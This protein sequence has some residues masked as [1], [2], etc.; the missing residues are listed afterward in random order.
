MQE[1]ATT[2]S[3]LCVMVSDGALGFAPSCREPALARERPLTAAQALGGVF[4]PLRSRDRRSGRKSDEARQSQVDPNARNRALGGERLDF[5]LEADEPLAV[6]PRQDGSAD[7]RTF[8][9]WS[10]PL[11][12]NLT[13]NAD[14]PE[15]LA[16]SDREAVTDAELGAD[17]PTLS[18]KAW[19][20]RFSMSVL[21]AT[22]ERLK[23]FVETPKNL[24]FSREAEPGP[25]LVSTA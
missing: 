8:G 1:V 25:S 2:G 22:E 14:N 4:R 10:V 11:D 21:Q 18:L 24:L 7:L 15:P 12:L 13:G 3:D 5:D 19:E 20:P 9:Q 6:R 16:L 17:E 23:G